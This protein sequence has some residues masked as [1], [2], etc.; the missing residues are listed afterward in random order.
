MSKYSLYR[1][2]HPGYIEVLYY[3]NKVYITRYILFPLGKEHITVIFTA[4]VIPTSDFHRI[5]T[6]DKG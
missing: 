5:K 1:I 3:P 6:K 2:L 4:F